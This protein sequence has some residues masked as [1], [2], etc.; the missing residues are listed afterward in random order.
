MQRSHLTAILGAAVAV[1]GLILFVQGPEVEPGVLRPFGLVTTLVALLVAAFDRWLWKIPLLHGWFV[2]RPNVA[3]TWVAEIRSTWSGRDSGES[4]PPITGYMAIRQ[5]FSSL[6][7]RLMTSE[8]TSQVLTAEITAADDGTYTISAVYQATP[9]AR[10]RDRSPIHHGGLLLQVADRRPRV[11][12]GTYWTDR[13]SS[14][15]LRLSDRQDGFFGD[16]ASAEAALSRS[17][18]FRST[19]VPHS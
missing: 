8:S 11:I 4:A 7:L 2:R 6:S 1:W 13:R 16:F 14:G 18:R 3:G 10:V 12:T 5:T 19:A 9:G 15:D 17:P